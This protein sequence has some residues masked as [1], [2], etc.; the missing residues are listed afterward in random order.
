[1]KRFTPATAFELRLIVNMTDEQLD[2]AADYFLKIEN[3]TPEEY[4]AACLLTNEHYRR[5][6][7]LPVPHVPGANVSFI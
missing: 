5:L 3:W 7:G 2:A 6:D 4:R 1:M